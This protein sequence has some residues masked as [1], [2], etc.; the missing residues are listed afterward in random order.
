MIIAYG[1]DDEEAVP[2]AASI[3]P[4]VLVPYFDTAERRRIL[5][6]VFDVDAEF[7]RVDAE[8]RCTLASLEVPDGHPEVPTV[9]RGDRRHP[10]VL[11]D[12]DHARVRG[13]GRDDG[14]GVDH[15]HAVR[16]PA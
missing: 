15:D 16:P 13:A 12:G 7:A 10:V 11:H 5:G 2:E 1:D 9:K 14:A 8:E 3:A 4:V 6:E